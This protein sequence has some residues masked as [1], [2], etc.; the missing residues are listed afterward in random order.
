MNAMVRIA[1]EALSLYNRQYN[2][3][4]SMAYTG[5]PARRHKPRRK[6]IQNWTYGTKYGRLHRG[7]LK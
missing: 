1:V 6:V 3:K 5:T 4:S 7:M 2:Y